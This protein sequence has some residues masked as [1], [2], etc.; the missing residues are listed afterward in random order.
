M[1]CCGN[2]VSWYPRVDAA[3]RSCMFSGIYISCSLSLSPFSSVPPPCLRRA[4]VPGPLDP[5]LPHSASAC[6]SALLHVF[7]SPPPLLAF[8]RAYLRSSAYVILLDCLSARQS[9]C[10]P[11]LLF[12]VHR[13]G[14]PPFLLLYLRLSPLVPL[15]ATLTR[16]SPVCTLC[17]G[18]SLCFFPPPVRPPACH[19]IFPIRMQ[20]W[21]SAYYPVALSPDGSRLAGALFMALLT[22]S[23]LHPPTAP[24]LPQLRDLICPKQ[25][26][27]WRLH[28]PLPL[29]SLTL[30]TTPLPSATPPLPIPYH[31]PLS[32]PLPYH[33]HPPLP[34]LPSLPSLPLTYHPP[35]PYHSHIT[36][37]PLPL[38]TPPLPYHSLPPLPLPYHSSPSPT[39]H[40]PPSPSPTTPIHHSHSLTTHISP[41]P[42]PT[43]PYHHSPSLPLLNHPSPLPYHSTPPSPFPTTTRPLSPAPTTPIPPT[44]APPLPNPPLEPRVGLR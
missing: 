28:P 1:A 36:L 30:A 40:I 12:V 16:P 8:L 11:A 6:L 14:F 26:G 3:W 41:S 33:P 29:P 34:L 37:L 15:V 4:S 35:L 13:P 43:T 23:A 20:V 25:I 44:P 31:P 39:N 17:D 24:S 2:A 42:S 9:L 18:L 5:F 19:S 27:L 7:S 32:L 38:P 21:L 22:H 10:F